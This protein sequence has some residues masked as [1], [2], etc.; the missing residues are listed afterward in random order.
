MLVVAEGGSLFGMDMNLVA[1]GNSTLEH[2]VPVDV[3]YERRAAVLLG[4]RTAITRPTAGG[5]LWR[6]GGR[7]PT[8]DRRWTFTTIR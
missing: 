8:G 6:A 3:F 2:N 1:D 4:D 5:D 7:S